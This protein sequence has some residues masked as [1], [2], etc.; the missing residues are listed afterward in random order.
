M[1]HVTIT[2]DTENAAFTVENEAEAVYHILREIA[3][4][5]RVWGLSDYVIRDVNG[6]TVGECIVSEEGE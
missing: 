6:N 2:L 1:A 4:A 3:V 5:W